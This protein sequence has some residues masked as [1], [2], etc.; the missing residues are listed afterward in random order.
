M[1][2]RR[3]FYLTLQNYSVF[4]A[5]YDTIFPNHDTIMTSSLISIFCHR[6]HCFV[7]TRG[8]SAACHCC[9]CLLCS[10]RR[11]CRH[12]VFHAAKLAFLRLAAGAWMLQRCAADVTWRATMF[13]KCNLVLAIRLLCNVVRKKTSAGSREPCFSADDAWVGSETLMLAYI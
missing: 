10:I 4:V 1:G 7:V 6:F 13:H 9:R 3:L 8:M 2:Y 12:L 5:Y 11:R